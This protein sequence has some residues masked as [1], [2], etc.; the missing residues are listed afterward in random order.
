MWASVALCCVALFTYCA[1][2][3][4]RNAG[5]AR[6]EELPDDDDNAPTDR[7]PSTHDKRTAE[8]IMRRMREESAN[9]RYV[10]GRKERLGGGEVVARQSDSCPRCRTAAPFATQ[11]RGRVTNAHTPTARRR[12]RD[13][14]RAGHKEEADA[15]MDEINARM[16]VAL[17]GVETATDEDLERAGIKLN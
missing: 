6:V 5:Q 3:P 10:A 17:E 2:P 8:E 14:A 11:V 4:V 15:L 9:I 13:L 16:E 12:V 7:P 1:Q